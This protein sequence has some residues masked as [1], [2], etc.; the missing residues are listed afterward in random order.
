[1]RTFLEMFVK[2]N[3]VFTGQLAFVWM[4]GIP[5][6]RVCRTMS[7]IENHPKND[8]LNAKQNMRFTMGF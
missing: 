1:M 2:K 6:C 8:T 4:T 5:T 3:F 7:D